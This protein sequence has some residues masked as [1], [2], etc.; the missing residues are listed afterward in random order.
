FES[1][2]EMAQLFRDRP[3]AL[4]HTVQIAQRCAFRPRTHQPILPRFSTSENGKALDEASEL[5]KRA[6]EG[7]QLRLETAGVAAGHTVDEYRERLDFEL[8]VIAGMKNPGYFL[9]VSDFIQWAEKQG[10]PLGPRPRSGA[11]LLL[12]LAFTLP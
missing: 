11:G 4:A 8:G 5:R 3:E 12:S 10:I 7:L 6:E 9:I 1:G 2:A